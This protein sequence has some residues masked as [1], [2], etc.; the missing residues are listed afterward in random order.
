MGACSFQIIT[1]YF[2]LVSI[3]EQEIEFLR[4]SNFIENERSGIALD[5]AIVAWKY[6]KRIKLEDLTV[7]DIL[8]THK[9]LMQNL[10][11]DI[12]GKF[13]ECTVWIGGREC[14]QL[15]VEVIRRLIADWLHTIQQVNTEKPEP[16]FILFLKKQLENIVQKSHVNFEH[17][18]PFQDGNGRVGRI[19]MMWYRLKVGL[20]VE[21]I[22]EAVKHEYYKW[23]K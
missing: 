21:V 6:I 17:I 2:R 22:Y 14:P 15:P 11:P 20:P 23:F 8:K 1:Y 3:T 10:R 13:R 9:L 4:Q 12:A 16:A 5:D 18:H 19:L 7:D